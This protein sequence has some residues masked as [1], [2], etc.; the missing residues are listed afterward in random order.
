M[1]DPGTAPQ[2]EAIQRRRCSALTLEIP[3]PTV[4]SGFA[5]RGEGRESDRTVS[6]V[7]VLEPLQFTQGA[8]SP[9]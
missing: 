7:F 1:S 5:V 6:G 3:K 9:S 2:S 8:A 4:V